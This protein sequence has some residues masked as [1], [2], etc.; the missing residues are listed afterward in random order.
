MDTA[1]SYETHIECNQCTFAQAALLPLNPMLH[2]VLTIRHQNPFRGLTLTGKIDGLARWYEVEETLNHDGAWPGNGIKVDLME[3]IYLYLTRV[4]HVRRSE[5]NF[6]QF[7]NEAI[8]NDVE[9][10]INF[11]IEKVAIVLSPRDCQRVLTAIGALNG[12]YDS[13]RAAEPIFPLK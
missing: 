11:D 13:G 4:Y 9:P 5:E 12:D 8:N 10:I 6:E 1:R 7:L 2:P 3:I